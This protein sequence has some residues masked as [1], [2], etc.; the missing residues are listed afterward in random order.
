VVF[1]DH[2]KYPAIADVTSDFVYARLQTGSDDIPTAYSPKAL[3]EWAKRAKLWARGGVP[4][5][6][7]VIDS[8]AKVKTE[9]RDTF[10]FFIHEGK[11]RAP[12]AA[13]EFMKRV[14]G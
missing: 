8:D 7:P 6:L 9:P 10:V 3:G 13:M 14:A 12:H 4:S 5:D 2:A 11:I 1:A